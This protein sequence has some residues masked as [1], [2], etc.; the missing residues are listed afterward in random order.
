VDRTRRRFLTAAA[1]SVGALALV[2]PASSQAATTVG[3]LAA[4]PTGTCDPGQIYHQ[5][6]ISG[7]DPAVT[8]DVGQVSGAAVVITSWAT[9]AGATGGQGALKVMSRD[10]FDGNTLTSTETVLHTS[11]VTNITA[12]QVNRFAVRIPV[13]GGGEIGYQPV[14]GSQQCKLD[15]ADVNNGDNNV[16]NG[17]S[18]GE[19]G[20]Q[21]TTN[22]NDAFRQLNLQVTFEPDADADGFGDET[23]DPCP[24]AQ[25]LVNGC[26]VPVVPPPPPPDVTKPVLAGGL[27]FT[28]SSFAAAKSG[29][30]FSAQ[31]GKKKKKAKKPSAPVGT[32]V[33]FNLTEAASVAFTVERKT[34]GRRDKGKCKTQTR[35]NRKKAK[36]T[37]WKKVTGSFTFPGKAGANSFTFRGRIGGKALKSGNYRLIGT[38]TDAARNVSV[39]TNKAFKIVK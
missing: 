1:V 20:S 34:T 6:I 11:E 37:L 14:V 26:P 18:T 7:D 36:C 10:A 23:Q 33:S 4:T 25:G 16:F 12:N 24:G 27:K 5:G 8:Y 9:R 22:S 32:K 38:A 15:P 31:R 29:G 35:K 28:R 30:A 17:A 21:Y 3:R 2:A 19:V 39:P 13:P